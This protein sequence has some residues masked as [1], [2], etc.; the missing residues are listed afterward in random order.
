MD[1]IY[2]ILGIFLEIKMDEKGVAEIVQ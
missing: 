2:I 1:I